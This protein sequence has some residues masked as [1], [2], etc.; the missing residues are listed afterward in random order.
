MATGHTH[1]AHTPW[2]KDSPPPASSSRCCPTASSSSHPCLEA[3]NSRQQQAQGDAAMRATLPSRCARAHSCGRYSASEDWQGWDLGVTP[4]VWLLGQADYCKSQETK[5]EVCTAAAKAQST[6]RQSKPQMPTPRQM[7]T[8]AGRLIPNRFTKSCH[9]AEDRLMGKLRRLHSHSPGEA[10]SIRC[11]HRA[12]TR[13]SS[14]KPQN[15]KR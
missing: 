12:L 15:A 13:T 1:T 3:G 8:R 11:C 14:T 2:C 4:G 10:C 6:Q 7:E 9:R 5:A